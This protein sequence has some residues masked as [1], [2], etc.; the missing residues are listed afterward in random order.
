MV[1]PQYFSCKTQLGSWTARHQ[2]RRL[3]GNFL[4]KFKLIFSTVILSEPLPGTMKQLQSV[5]SLSWS[6]SREKQRQCILVM[7]TRLLAP[8]SLRH[9]SLAHLWRRRRTLESGDCLRPTTN[10]DDTEWKKGQLQGDQELGKFPWFFIELKFQLWLKKE[11]SYKQIMSSF[12][13]LI[14]QDAA[15]FNL[16]ESVG[17]L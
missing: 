6:R 5:V 7:D 13:I 3:E 9:Q 14:T 2:Q 17:V 4:I 1:Y 10:D 12:V 11:L 8:S 16:P 15:E